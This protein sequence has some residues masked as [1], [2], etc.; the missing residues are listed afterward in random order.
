MRQRQALTAIGHPRKPLDEAIRS[1]WLSCPIPAAICPGNT[2]SVG[3]QFGAA[4]SK[5]TTNGNSSKKGF[6]ADKARPRILVAID[7]GGPEQEIAKTVAGLA[8]S[9]S[10]EIAILHVCQPSSRSSAT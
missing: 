6:E 1:N 8:R 4:M 5:T 3:K 7:N 9:L 10:A 2:R